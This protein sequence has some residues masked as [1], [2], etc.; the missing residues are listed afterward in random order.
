MRALIAIGIS[1]LLFDVAIVAF[2]PVAA[3]IQRWRARRRRERLI[4]DLQA[5]SSCDLDDVSA[6]LWA[7]M[8]RVNAQRGGHPAYRDRG[9]R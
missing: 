5:L 3:A 7:D 9:E 4:A 8:Y 6:S 2:V 1:W